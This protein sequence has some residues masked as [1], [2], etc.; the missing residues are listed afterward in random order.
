VL[1]KDESQADGERTIEG[2]ARR[3]LG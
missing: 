3:V 2:V 1:T